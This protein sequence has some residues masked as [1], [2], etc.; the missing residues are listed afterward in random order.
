MNNPLVELIERATAGQPLECH[1]VAVLQALYLAQL[2]DDFV[3]QQSN[4]DWEADSDLATSFGLAES[5][6]D[7]QR[8]N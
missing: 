2:G 1:R 6:Y 8:D 5:A 7:G 4:R 3:Q